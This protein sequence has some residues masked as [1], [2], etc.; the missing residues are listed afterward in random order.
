MTVGITGGGAAYKMNCQYSDDGGTSWY[1]P[2]GNTSA[3]SSIGSSAGV[4]AI[5]GGGSYSGSWV[6]LPSAAKADVLWRIVHGGGNNSSPTLCN[7][8]IHF[9]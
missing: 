3:L 8:S 2:D 1:W 9:K 4:V 7:A 5:S 6:T